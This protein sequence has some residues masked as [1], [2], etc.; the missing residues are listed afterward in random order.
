MSC[1]GFWRSEIVNGLVRYLQPVSKLHLDLLPGGRTRPY[2]RLLQLKSL[3]V[4]RSMNFMMSGEV[5]RRTL[6]KYVTWSVGNV[7]YELQLFLKLSTQPYAG[8][9]LWMKKYQTKFAKGS[10]LN[11]GLKDIKK[12][13]TTDF[14]ARNSQRINRFFFSWEDGG[15]KKD[16]EQ[17]PILLL[18]G[19]ER[20][21]RPDV[22]VKPCSF[23]HCQKIWVSVSSLEENQRKGGEKKKDWCQ[24]KKKLQKTFPS[25]K[26]K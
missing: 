12:M 5:N 9:F 19:R 13:R 25:I 8:F 11:P 21:R 24:R 1:D 23:F 7:R 20:R 3:E 26:M 15:Q 2:Y 6:V 4:R 16:R 18:L 10:L 14:Q 22:P 17:M